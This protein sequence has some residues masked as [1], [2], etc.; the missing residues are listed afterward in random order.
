M[1][2]KRLAIPSKEV[3]LFLVGARDSFKASRVQRFN[4]NADIPNT[5]NDEIG[6]STHAGVSKDTPN[7]TVSFSAFD[8]SIKL[9]SALTGTNPAAYPAGGVDIVN[10]SEIDV[11]AYVKSP[12]AAKYIKS[13]HGKRLQIRDFTFNYSVDGDST[14]DYT[15]I[16][17][18]RRYFKN[19]VVIDKFTTGTTSF[20]LSKTPL[21][22]KNGDK[23]LSVVLDGTYLAEVTSGP[24]V[25][26]YS[27]SGTT[28][29][30]GDSMVTQALVV[31]HG[32]DNSLVWSDVKDDTIPAAIKGKNV[33]VKIVALDIPR[34]QSVSINGTLNVQP[35]KEM[36]NPAVVGYQRQIP[37][38]TGTITVL[39]TDN[40]LVNIFE[41]GTV[42]TS[43]IA[44]WQPGEGCTTSGFPLTITIYDPCDE[45]VA[46]KRVYIPELTITSDAFAVNVNGNA[47]STYNWKS[48]TAECIIFSGA[49]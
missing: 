46:L 2:G 12:T 43:G 39:D 40:E 7:I 3:Q 19:D 35:V 25:G 36:N 42:T 29:T 20:A 21:Q 48:N 41:N 44:E 16:G 47:S 1:A 37:D 10:L 30:T 26:E 5:N 11:V 13:I 9:F 24:S 28:L 22:L 27:V 4:I 34:V 32:T 6:S 23:L 15:A 31:Y 49:A 45:T 14:E 38:V 18:E 8:T 33:G 17:S